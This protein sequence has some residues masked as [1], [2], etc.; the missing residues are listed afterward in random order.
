MSKAARK[1]GLGPES[2]YKALSAE[3]DPEFATIMKVIHSLG[4]RLQVYLG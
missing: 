2:L 3:G 4:L 1:A